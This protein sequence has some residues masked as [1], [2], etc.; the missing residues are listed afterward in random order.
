MSLARSLLLMTSAALATASCGQTVLTLEDED[1]V[2]VQADDLETDGVDTESV[3]TDVAA[4][5]VPATESVE[6]EVGELTDVAPEPSAP[7][8]GGGSEQEPDLESGLLAHFHFDEEQ[9]GATVL[10]ASG[11]GHHGQPSPNPPTPSASVPP[12]GFDNPR[13]L[14]FDGVEQLVD[15]G[16]PETLDVGGPVTISAWIRPL[17]L[18]GFR[19]IVAHG[20]RRD[21]GQELTLRINDGVYEFN[22]WEGGVFDHYARAPVPS[23]DV[24]NWHHLAGTYDGQ[25]YRLYRDGRLMAEREDDFAPTMVDAPWAIGGRSATTPPEGRFFEG[26]IDEVRIYGRALSAEEIQLLFR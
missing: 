5:D 3:P 9:A 18:D 22:V 2:Q 15:L 4:T 26:A 8:D 14:S 17:A 21:P 6:T 12:V 10:D 16:N 13:S 20:F 19:N 7:P 23:G 11:N 1:G 24:D 25:A